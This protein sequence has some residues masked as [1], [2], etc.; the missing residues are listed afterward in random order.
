MP[1][2]PFDLGVVDVFCFAGSTCV[3][4]GLNF[5]DRICV[6]VGALIGALYNGLVAWG[7]E[8]GGLA[9][10]RLTK[11]SNDWT[12][13]LAVVCLSAHCGRDVVS[14]WLLVEGCWCIR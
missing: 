4:G 2:R 10:G 13:V 7:L 12:T 11:P 1:R 6:L 5:V 8:A 14:E 9:A 3:V